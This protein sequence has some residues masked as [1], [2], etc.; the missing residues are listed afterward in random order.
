MRD[1][2]KKQG[3]CE[4][5]FWVHT[6]EMNDPYGNL[7]FDYT[8]DGIHLSLLGYQKLKQIVEEGIKI[9]RYDVI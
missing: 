5:V 9:N 3:L 4:K 1:G 2:L 8:I 6:D 7:N